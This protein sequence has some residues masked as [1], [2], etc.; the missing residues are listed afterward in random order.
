MFVDRFGKHFQFSQY[1]GL[2]F[3]TMEAAF[4]YFEAHAKLQKQRA[5]QANARPVNCAT[6]QMWQFDSSLEPANARPVVCLPTPCLRQGAP[7]F[8]S[9]AES[10]SQEPLRAPDPKH[11]SSRSSPPEFPPYTLFAESTPHARDIQAQT[12]AELPAGGFQSWPPVELPAEKLQSSTLRFHAM[13]GFDLQPF[14]PWPEVPDQAN[15]LVEN[16]TAPH[17]D[18]SFLTRSSSS[19]DDD[20]LSQTQ[21][22]HGS[23]SLASSYS[24]TVLPQTLARKDIRVLGVP[25]TADI[26]E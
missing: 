11:S 5:I 21:T 25:L 17:Y 4:D 2:T 16:H 24:G 6:Q 3:S 7:C 20:I 26:D 1:P 22:S 18:H 9:A 12:P 8:E 19:T 14:L 23:C 13:N 10:I 15:T